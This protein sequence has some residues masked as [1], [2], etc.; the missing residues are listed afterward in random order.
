M[1]ELLLIDDDIRGAGDG[2]AVMAATAL[3]AEQ[4]QHHLDKVPAGRG[5]VITVE[6]EV[7][8]GEEPAKVEEAEEAEEG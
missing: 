1:T 3:V 2:K 5:M 4:L 6:F 7:T 8:G